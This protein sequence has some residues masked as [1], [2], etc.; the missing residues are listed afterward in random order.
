MTLN[1]WAIGAFAVVAL[2]ALYAV[3]IKPSTTFVTNELGSASSPSVVNGCMEV[4][5]QNLCFYSQRMANASTTCSF[6]AQATSTVVSAAAKVTNAFGGSFDVAWG[7]SVSP[8]AT[9]TSLGYKIAAIASDQGTFVATSSLYAP[10]GTIEDPTTVLGPGQY[11]N[12]KVGS[13]SPTVQGSCSAILQ[14]I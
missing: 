3:F 9:T 4:N 8:N 5:G 11:L 6:R 13:T 7:T 12:F 2:L 10:G 14:I 1:K